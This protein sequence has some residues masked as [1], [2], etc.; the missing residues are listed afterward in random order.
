MAV[1]CE[2]SENLRAS[3]TYKLGKYTGIK[4]KLEEK[5]YDTV[6]DM[7]LFGSLGTWDRENDPL[8]C[9]LV[10]PPSAGG[11][12]ARFA[13]WIGLPLACLNIFQILEMKASARLSRARAS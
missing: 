10:R 8:L 1:P 11:E 4:A 6:L 7:L 2:T 9:W 12:S 5:G 13:W 3:R